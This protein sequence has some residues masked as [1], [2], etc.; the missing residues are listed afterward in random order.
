MCTARL[1]DPPAAA[2]VSP[3]GSIPGCCNPCQLV[4]ASFESGLISILH[5][6]GRAIA[7]CQ[8]AGGCLGTEAVLEGHSNCV[9]GDT[10]KSRAFELLEAGLHPCWYSHKSMSA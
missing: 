3:A 5:S 6:R 4:P 10:C 8:V 9:Q 1:Q 7:C 2:A